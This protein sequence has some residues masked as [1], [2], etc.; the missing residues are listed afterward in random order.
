LAKKTWDK[1]IIRSKIILRAIKI[2]RE[3]YRDSTFNTQI[4]KK[5]IS[6]EFDSC[7]KLKLF[8]AQW[9]LQECQTAVVYS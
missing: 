8:R 6:F 7:L 5:T 2:N 3:K 9:T 4:Q 1:I